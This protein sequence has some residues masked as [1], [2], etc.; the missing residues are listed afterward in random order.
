MTDL[1]KVETFHEFG[2]VLKELSEGRIGELYYLPLYLKYQQLLNQYRFILRVSL[3]LG[4][5]LGLMVGI[6]LPL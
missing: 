6:T 3:L 5:V 1:E 2:R 4:F